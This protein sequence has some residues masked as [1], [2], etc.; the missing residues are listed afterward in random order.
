MNNYAKVLFSL[1]VSLFACAVQQKQKCR[2]LT[3]LCAFGQNEWVA[4]QF[5]PAL[6]QLV[7][8]LHDQLILVQNLDSH[9]AHTQFQNLSD[10]GS[11]WQLVVQLSQRMR[12]PG[13]WQAA[14]MKFMRDPERASEHDRVMGHVDIFLNVYR[15]LNLRSI[16]DYG[17]LNQ[18]FIRE[19]QALV[20][21]HKSARVSQLVYEASLPAL[22]PHCEQPL[23]DPHVYCIGYAANNASIWF[24]LDSLLISRS[25]A[26]T[27]KFSE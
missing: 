1:A 11:V 16:R 4:K 26:G 17:Q 7:G 15:S 21:A 3:Y 20:H 6:E 27:Q 5:V 2:P 18:V 23:I 12:S 13:V 14:Y 19:Y 9:N 25:L 8:I 10:A 22:W 24:D